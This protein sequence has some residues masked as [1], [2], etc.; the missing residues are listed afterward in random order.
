[1]LPSGLHNE[2]ESSG[3]CCKGI[4]DRHL[5]TRLPIIPASWQAHSC[6]VP[7]PC[8]RTGP[9]ELYPVKNTT[10][11]TGCHFQDQD[12]KDWK[13]PHAHTLSDCSRALALMKRAVILQSDQWKIPCSKKLM[14]S[15]LTLKKWICQQPHEWTWKEILPWLSLHARLQPQ[16][17]FWLQLMRDGVK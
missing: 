7:C 17:T 11:M 9:C 4:C 10:D 8:V 15:S 13:F 5:P 1:M 12:T 16:P 14:L 3:R 2:F 6:V